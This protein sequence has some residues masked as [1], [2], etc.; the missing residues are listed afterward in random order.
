MGHYL[1]TKWLI[2]RR[3]LHEAGQEQLSKNY[4]II[5]VT[6]HTGLGDIYI[7]D[8]LRRETFLNNRG[9]SED[10]PLT[11]HVSVGGV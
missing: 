11:S 4:K 1:N 10:K 8:S 3:S 6:G 5:I 7:P 9:I 2:W